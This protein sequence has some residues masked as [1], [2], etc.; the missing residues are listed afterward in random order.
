MQLLRPNNSTFWNKIHLQ[1]SNEPLFLDPTDPY[2]RIKIYAIEAGGFDLVAK[3][4]EDAKTKIRAPKFYLDKEEQTVSSRTEYKKMR[5]KALSELE[6]LSNK[7]TTK[8]FYIAKVVD[9]HSVQYRKSTP[10]DV[11]YEN[12][13]KHI[14][15]EGTESN[16]ERAVKSFLDA[17]KSDMQSLKL[18]AIV[19]DSAYYKLI[20][21]KSDGYLYHTKSGSIL[22]RNVSDVVEYLKNPMNEDIYKALNEEIEKLWNM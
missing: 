16:M 1:C 9:A 3:S 5:N 4:Y 18:R 10:T 17:V 12:M 21:N 2:D 6:T 22:G 14:N 15:G 19:K 13:D 20:T 8:L 7:N 11:I